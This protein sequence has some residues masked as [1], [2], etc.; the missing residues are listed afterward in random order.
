MISIRFS[1]SCLEWMQM[2]S[3][4]NTS[5]NQDKIF[6]DVLTFECWNHKATPSFLWEKYKWTKGCNHVN[7]EKWNHCAFKTAE[8]KHETDDTLK[9]TERDE[10]CFETHEWN[11]LFKEALHQSTCWREAKNF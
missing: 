1:I 7:K 10:E 2:R 11:C 5:S 9:D 3:N 6:D 4:N 8:Q